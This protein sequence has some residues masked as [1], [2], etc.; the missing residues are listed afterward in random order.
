M[1]VPLS[2]CLV[3]K[4]CIIPDDQVRHFAWQLLS[5][6]YGWVNVADVVKHL[7]SVSRPEKVLF[8]LHIH[9]FKV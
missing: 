4:H 1:A 3:R 5:S 9:A 2:G 7:E 8:K 6:L